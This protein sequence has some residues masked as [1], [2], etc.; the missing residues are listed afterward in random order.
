MHFLPFREE[1]C[2][3]LVC[4][5]LSEHSGNVGLDVHST[6]KCPNARIVVY[7]SWPSTYLSFWRHAELHTLG[8]PHAV[9]ARRYANTV[10]TAFFLLRSFFVLCG[11]GTKIHSKAVFFVDGVRLSQV[12]VVATGAL[13]RGCG[14]HLG[15]LGS[16]DCVLAL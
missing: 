6:Q 16:H 10:S 2:L 15:F 9:E 3:T 4:R 5:N 1:S 13:I 8:A 12:G 14:S 11:S 7:S